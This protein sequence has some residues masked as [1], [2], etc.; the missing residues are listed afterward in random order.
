[1]GAIRPTHRAAVGFQQVPS[2]RAFWGLEGP[3]V[4]P[5]VM[6]GS[7]SGGSCGVTPLL[8]CLGCAPSL[9]PLGVLG[10]GSGALLKW[11]WGG[12][13]GGSRT[14]DAQ[15]CLGSGGALSG[16]QQCYL[17]MGAGWNSSISPSALLRGLCASHTSPGPLKGPQVS[18]PSCRGSEVAVLGPGHS[19]P[20]VCHGC[21]PAPRG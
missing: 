21:S 16:S 4:P 19:V 11:D 5:C 14:S 12:H 18:L 1:M 3:L 6:H 2:P 7:P 13:G 10:M 9:A 20:C 15:L 17:M 8:A